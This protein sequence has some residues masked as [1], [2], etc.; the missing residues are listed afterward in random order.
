MDFEEWWAKQTANF[1]P[2]EIGLMQLARVTWHAAQDIER[3]ACAKVCE[4]H[5]SADWF[6]N[7][8]GEM[9]D[10]PIA[11]NAIVTKCASAI[12]ARLTLSE[13]ARGF[14]RVP[15]ARRVMPVFD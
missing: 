7:G 2:E 9:V 8:D 6:R 12:R 13:G 4:A 5:K 15:L 10:K 1:D 14:S 11:T 3:E